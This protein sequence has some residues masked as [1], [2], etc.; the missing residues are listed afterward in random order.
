MKVVEEDMKNEYEI[1][2]YWRLRGG[3]GECGVM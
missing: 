1:Q 3:G 2:L